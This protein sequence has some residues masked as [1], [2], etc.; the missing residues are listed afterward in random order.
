MVDIHCHIL[1]QVDDGPKSW[2]VSVEMCRIAIADGIVHIVAT[3]HANNRYDYD[4]ARYASLLSE[5]CE[6]LQGASL[7]L[8]L[9]CDFHL[10]Y[11]NIQDALTHPGRYVI[12]DTRYL[13]VE[14]SDFSIPP[15]TSEFFW[16]FMGNGITP[17]LTHPERNPILQRDLKRILQWVEK[18]CVVQVTGNALT[19]RWGEPARKAAVWLLD[20]HAVHVIASDA[21]NLDSRPPVL[22]TARDLVAESYGPEVAT[23][24]L[25]D[26]PEAI[27]TSRALPYFPAVSGSRS[28]SRALR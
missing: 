24:L 5:L 21:H 16:Q 25:Q 26:N 2:D 13:L 6:R 3:P 10:S 11:E 12:G 9:G 19:G 17:I 8:T 27:V 28:D 4:R 23:A 18:G 14:F 1:P 20:N 7:R 15:Q 22:S